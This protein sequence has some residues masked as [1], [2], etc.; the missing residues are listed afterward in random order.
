MLTGLG[1][2]ATRLRRGSRGLER[3][4]TNSVPKVDNELAAGLS[5]N[6]GIFATVLVSIAGLLGGLFGYVLNAKFEAVK[7]SLD[8]KIGYEAVN[9]LI[10]ASIDRYHTRIV[11]DLKRDVEEKHRE[12][13][14]KLDT[15]YDLL[16][17]E[18]YRGG[19]M[20]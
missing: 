3:E 11:A 8:N 19:T 15:I 13:T 18:K 12:N 14:K 20:P 2:E 17:R 7:A 5:M 10:E 16:V 4:L 6:W 1:G 9:A